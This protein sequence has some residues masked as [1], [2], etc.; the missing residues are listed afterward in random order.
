MLSPRTISTPSG[1]SMTGSSTEKMRSIESARIMLVVWSKPISLPCGTGLRTTPP[2]KRV[3]FSDRP[4]SRAARGWE[5]HDDDSTILCD[6]EDFFCVGV[7][8]DQGVRWRER[9]G[10]NFDRE[11]GGELA[12]KVRWAIV[13]ARSLA[14]VPCDSTQQLRLR[15]QSK[16]VKRC[17][18]GT[19]CR[20]RS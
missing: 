8:S 19:H 10:T 20:R 5:T 15:R 4:D 11:E 14:G 13:S 16:R 6:D 3:S 18:C 2:K 9:E 1:S 17:R 7:S 12:A